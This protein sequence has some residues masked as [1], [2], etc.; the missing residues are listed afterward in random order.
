MMPA[1]RPAAE[2][3]GP[4]PAERTDRRKRVLALGTAVA[5][6]VL[7]AGGG[8]A[9]AV[10]NGDD[11]PGAASPPPSTTSKAASPL[12]ADEQCTEEIMS[13]PRWVC[14]TSAAVADGT[15]TIRYETDGAPMSIDGGHHLHV[16]GGDGTNPP[17]HVMG[18]HAHKSEQGKWYVEDRRPAVLDLTDQRYLTAIGDA[19]KVCARVAAPDHKLVK[20]ADGSYRTGNCVPIT[21]NRE[22]PVKE[23]PRT[24]RNDDEPHRPTTTTETTTTTTEPSTTEPTPDSEPETP[25][26]EEAA[27]E[28][29]AP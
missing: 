21:G 17:E 10:F 1:E 29:P 28:S 25:P 8:V 24:P 19:P 23:I 20:A 26:S 2:P 16:Y 18:R 15:L 11:N 5:V 14:L 22:I 6:M 13:S 9:L 3:V 27:G 12:P 7:L 4:P